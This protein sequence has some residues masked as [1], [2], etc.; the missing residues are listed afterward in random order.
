MPV[1]RTYNTVT[2]Q[3]LHF[4]L[5]PHTGLTVGPIGCAA[6]WR[7]DARSRDSDWIDRLSVDAVTEFDRAVAH[8]RTTGKPLAK[9]TAA[10]LPLPTLA[11]R[12]AQWP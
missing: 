6:A 12:V 5:R 10:D 8:A 9:L 1:A 2:R 4:P 3:A 7:G 11:P